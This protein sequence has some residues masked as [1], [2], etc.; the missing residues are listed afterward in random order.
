MTPSQPRAHREPEWP[1]HRDD[2]APAA[3][4]RSLRR[5]LLAGASVAMVT[6]ALLLAGPWSTQA[7][8]TLLGLGWIAAVGFGALAYRGRPPVVL[9]L[10]K[11]ALLAGLA[12]LAGALFLFLVSLQ[13]RAILEGTVVFGTAGEGCTVEGDGDSFG[14]GQPSYQVA[15]LARTIAAGELVTLTMLQ[16]GSEVARGSSAAETTFDCLGA[17]LEPLPAG[18]YEVT[19]SIGH[20]RLADG[21]FTVVPGDR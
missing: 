16:D 19:V 6:L 13:V 5:G 12:S 15:H 8:G 11:L 9:G 2:A 18:D 10:I 21:R 3:D 4:P 17:P 14:Y 7:G 1:S 20:E